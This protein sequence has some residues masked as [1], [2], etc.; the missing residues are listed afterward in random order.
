M[1]KMKLAVC[2]SFL[3]TRGGTQKV[4]LKIAQHF[5]AKVYCSIYD[6]EK[7]YPE[8]K[9]LEVEVLKTRF[10]PILRPFSK[11][12]MSAIKGGLEF[13][14]LKLKDYDVINAQGTPSEWVRNRNSPVVWYS[15]S[16]NREAF[17]LYEFRMKQR[18]LL[19]K[20]LFWSL[21]QHYKLIENSL[22][23]R[24][25]YVF[26]NSLN[27]QGR[28]KKYLRVNSEVLHP[29]I[30]YE[31]FH[32]EDYKK[33]FLYP[34]RITPEKRFEFA[35]EAFKRFKFKSRDKEWKLVIVGALDEARLE[36]VN[37]YKRISDMCGDD[38]EIKLNVSND[39]LLNLYANCYSVLYSPIDEDFGII[40]LEALSSYKPCIAV[41]EGGPKEVLIDGVNGFLVGSSQEM[42]W[43]MSYLEGHPDVV[44]K[45]GKDGRKHVEENFSWDRFLSRFKEVCEKVSKRSSSG[46]GS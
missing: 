17:D 38:V 46:S 2:H 23:P 34:S 21:I 24:I 1:R 36:H 42:A 39:E 28:L 10:Y 37:Y 9:E 33:Y 7:T 19:Q 13:Y 20:A 44:E 15:H 8:F 35:I 12:V 30:D 4:V 6:A 45:M 32:C 25:E 43:K 14:F 40:P 11:R 3:D 31:R 22:V 5:D 27:T 16:P 41:N 26:A 29:G 18:K